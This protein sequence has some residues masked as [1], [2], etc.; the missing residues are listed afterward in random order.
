MLL[1]CLWCTIALQAQPA[2]KPLVVMVHYT[3]QPGKGAEAVKA[4]KLLLAEVKKEPHYL[5]IRMLVQPDKPESILLYEQWAQAEYY[6]GAHMQTPHLQAFIVA[7]RAFLAGP[8]E[9]SF[10][11]SAD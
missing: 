11:Q 9:I 10:W 2:E 4:L 1:I 8:P 5:G 6:R 7:S 3:A